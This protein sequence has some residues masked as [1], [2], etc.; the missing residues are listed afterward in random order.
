LQRKLRFD[1][2]KEAFVGDDE[3]NRLRSR[4]ARDPWA[5]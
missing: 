3:A 4:P 2:E 5:V 1:P